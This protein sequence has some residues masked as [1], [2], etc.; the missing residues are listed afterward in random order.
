LKSTNQ[1]HETQQDLGKINGA[2]D[3]FF[4]KFHLATIFNQSGIRKTKG[5]SALTIMSSIFA[6]A[7]IGKDFFRGIVQN[8]SAPFGKDAAYEL[9]KG[10]CHNW[11][12]VLMMIS[13]KLLALFNSLTSQTRE[14]VLIIDDSPYDRSRSKKVELLAR[15]FDHA[16][17]RFIR[18][19]RLLSVCWSDGVSLLPLD[20]ALLSSRDKKNRFQGI[21]KDVDKRSCGYKRRLEA[22]EKATDLVNPMVGRILSY[23]IKFNY[24][25]MD[26]WFCWPK[27]VCALHQYAPV[28]GMVKKTSKVLY[29]F[30]GLELDVKSIYRRLPKR[31]GRAQILS[32]AL[33]RVGG[34]DAKLVFVRDRRKKDWLVLLSTSPEISNE[35]IVRLYGRRWDIEVFF[36]MAKQH[37][38]LVKEIQARDFDTLVAHTSIVFMRYQFLAYEQ[39]IRTDNRTFG[40]LFYC[41]YEEMA[42]IAFL[43]SLQRILTMAIDKLRKAGEFSEKIYRKLIDVVM[44]Q[45]VKLLGLESNQCQIAAVTA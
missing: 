41:V 14:K 44:G 1:T 39:R 27:V 37:L 8:Q 32:H 31:R 38:K 43:E 24:I 20:F 4:Q 35:E 36:K 30:G 6:L 34:I 33:I 23:R 29:N 5:T 25:L 12:K 17:K 9:L 21:T 45:A 2:I 22:M 15:V 11:R 18:G 10:S 28:I 16:E 3:R 19:F 13:V 7:F 42:D 40:Q 26:S